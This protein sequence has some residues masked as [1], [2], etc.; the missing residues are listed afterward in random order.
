MGTF[1]AI[2]METPLYD[3]IVGNIK[4]ASD[5]NSPNPNWS[6]KEICV[7]TSTI[8]KQA[9]AFAIETRGQKAKKE[10]K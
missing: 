5:S 8:S 9:D 6:P 2:V 3:L 10:K 1:Q 7:E 4:E